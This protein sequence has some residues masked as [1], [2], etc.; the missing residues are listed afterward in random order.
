MRR[1]EATRR[2]HSSFVQS[3]DVLPPPTR[4]LMPERRH[5][6]RID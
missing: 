3:A 2:F 1:K 4:R 6:A 5:D